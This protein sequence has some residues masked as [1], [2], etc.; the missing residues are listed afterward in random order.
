MDYRVKIIFC[1]QALHQV[2]VPD[3][4]L[5]KPITGIIFNSLQIFQVSRVSKQIEI[6]EQNKGL[7][8][9]QYILDEI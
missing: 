5:Y 2:F 9:L 6:H 7:L 8:V 1:K 4:S 3:V